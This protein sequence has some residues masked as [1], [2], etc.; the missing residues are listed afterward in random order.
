MTRHFVLTQR[1]SSSGTATTLAAKIKIEGDAVSQYSTTTQLD[2]S[3]ALSIRNDA[4]EGWSFIIPHEDGVVSTLT[5]N[6]DGSLEALRSVTNPTIG[7]ELSLPL[8]MVPTT[9]GG[10]DQLSVW[11]NPGGTVNVEYV[12]MKRDGT[13]TAALTN[14]T[15]DGERGAYLVQLQPLTNVGAP[16]W[17][18]FQPSTHNWY[19]RHHLRITN[20]NGGKVS[21]PIAL[22]G[23]P[24]AAFYIT[25]G[26][27]LFRD[28]NSEPIGAPIQISKNWHETPFWY[29]LYTA[30]EVPSGT[31]ELEHTFA[32]AKWGEAYAASHA[33]LSLIGWSDKNQQ[34]DE[35]ALACFG[36]SVTYD[37][38][39]TLSRAQVDD[40]RP[41]LVQ[42]DRKWHWTGNVGGASFLVYDSQSG[43]QSQ[44]DHQGGAI[45]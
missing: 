2:G 31:Q 4:G 1:V 34:W 41:F 35:S 37:P 27:P 44:P 3:R 10:D 19:N 8:I 38:D 39:L 11:L 24:N 12:Q 26:S 21:I 22:D 45:Q 28:N 25:G 9:A 33:H 36:E 16:Y 32:H 6:G 29:H 7:Q 20:N 42:A 23:G 15:F 5:R 14:A 43:R 30:L 18:H 17:G 13:L 40:V